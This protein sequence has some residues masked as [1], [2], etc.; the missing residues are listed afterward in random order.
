MII[1]NSNTQTLECIVLLL[2]RLVHTKQEFLTQLCDAIYVIPDGIRVFQGL[3]GLEKRTPRIVSDLLAILNEILRTQNGNVELVEQIIQRYKSTG[4][5]DEK[6]FPLH[7]LCKQI[8]GSKS[9]KK[10]ILMFYSDEIIDLFTKLLSHKQ[11]K[12]RSRVC[13]FL[14]LLGKFSQKTLQRVWGKAL[15]DLLENLAESR[16]DSVQ[17]VRVPTKFISIF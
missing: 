7:Y 15:R 5:F 10:N 6:I 17:C 14:L 8:K 13:I 9:K 11:S 2:C 12:P 1:L 4:K 3:L 16:E